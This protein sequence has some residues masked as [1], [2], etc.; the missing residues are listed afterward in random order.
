ILADLA[1]RVV[2]AGRLEFSHDD[3]ECVAVGFGA[4]KPE[5]FRR[6]QPQELVAPRGGLEFEFLVVREAL[7]EG[8]F[9]LVEF[10]HAFASMLN[11]IPQITCRL[12]YRG[13]PVKATGLKRKHGHCGAGRAG[14]CR[15][16]SAAPSASFCVTA[17][18]R[19]V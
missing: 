11:E 5:L 19:C 6:P 13:Y 18:P 15:L 14:L 1:R 8:L 10:G 17:G 2:I 9:A 4:G 7:L 16:Y 3:R 12:A